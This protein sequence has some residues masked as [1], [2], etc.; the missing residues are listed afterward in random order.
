MKG[1]T[2]MKNRKPVELY[3]M[4]IEVTRRCNMACP[5]CLRGEA[6]GINIDTKYIDQALEH[7]EF[8]DSLTFTG[9]EPTL[10]LDAIRYTLEVC[11]AR[12]IRV[13]SFYIVTNGKGSTKTMLDFATLCL[14]WYAYCLEDVAYAAD[15]YS[16]VALSKDIFHEKIPA[17]NEAILRGLAIFRE[18]KFNDFKNGSLINEGRAQDLDWNK[19][20]SY[21]DELR[22]E[23]W[24]DYF[25]V[26]GMVYLSAN[27]DIK[28]NCDIAFNNSDCTIGNL[29]DSDFLDIIL[30]Q[31][32]EELDKAG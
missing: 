32:D 23:E 7:I 29:N 4:A 17:V 30:S 12:N 22:V 2:P 26:D 15:C 13:G 27:G 21:N 25:G 14:E 16:G 24:D 8:I 28:T 18:D 3:S 20:R 9:G 19:R 10:N 31:W 1:R 5:H 11:K 6:Q